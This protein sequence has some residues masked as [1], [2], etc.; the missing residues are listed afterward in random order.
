MRTDVVIIGCGLVGGMTAKYLRKQGLEVVVVDDENLMSGSKCSFG[1]WKEGWVNK[2][3]KEEYKD[4][5]DL[6]DEFGGGITETEFIIKPKPYKSRSMVDKY[7]VKKTLKREIFNHVHCELIM[8]ELLVVRGKVDSIE[9]NRVT[10]IKNKKDK[11]VIVAKLIVVAAGVWTTD[12]LLENGLNIDLPYL[13]FQWGSVFRLKGLDLPLENQL[14]EWSPYKHSLYFRTSFNT[15]IF[16]DGVTVKNPK[17]N[18]ERLKVNSDRILIHMGELLGS[19]KYGGNIVDIQE[20]YRPY[21][22][23]E[24]TMTGKFV[25][26]HS[27][28]VISATGGAK[29]SVVLCGHMA[30]EV[31]RLFKKG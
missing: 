7:I 8:K 10:V 25:N 21:L 17:E 20:G 5:K 29:N 12:I 3:I 19:R 31:W 6:L 28:W 13:D 22:N 15:A 30:K 11:E 14:R 26:R 4:G 18:D 16:G 1:V 2:V 9:G 24:K 23:K 27:D